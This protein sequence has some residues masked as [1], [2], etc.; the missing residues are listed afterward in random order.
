MQPPIR[1]E[2]RGADNELDSSTAGCSAPHTGFSSHVSGLG[3]LLSTDHDNGQTRRMWGNFRVDMDKDMTLIGSVSAAFLAVV[4]TIIFSQ[5]FATQATISLGLAVMICS[6]SLI[7]IC[8][9]LVFH[10]SGIQSS[11]E[12]LQW[13]NNARLMNRQYFKPSHLLL[14]PIVDFAF[15]LALVLIFI[16]LLVWGPTID[17]CMGQPQPL[18]GIKISF[19]TFKLY[20]L[21]RQD[22]RRGV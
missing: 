10:L 20:Q 7:I 11:G 13:V 9:I 4:P 12:E 6:I 8:F 17:P 15:D 14:I 5:C 1:Q 19:F 18:V 2:R 22:I 21:R 3:L 16:L